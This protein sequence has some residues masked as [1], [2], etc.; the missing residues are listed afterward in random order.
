MMNQET[1]T[2]TVLSSRTKAAILLMSLDA[3][4]PGLS[5]QLLTKM[6]ESQSKLLLQEINQLGQ[7]DKTMIAT[8]IDEFYALS[9]TQE[10]LIGG[11]TIMMPRKSVKKPGMKSKIPLIK[12]RGNDNSSSTLI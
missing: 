7:I 9:I 1:N 8:V 2:D 5:Q 3:K 10:S 12:T 11:K 4:M 6:D